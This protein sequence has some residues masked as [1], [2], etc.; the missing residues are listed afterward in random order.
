MAPIK[1]LVKSDLL[2]HRLKVNLKTF[3]SAILKDPDF[4]YVFCL[5][6]ERN[7]L[8]N[9]LLIRLWGG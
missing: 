4:R 5:R 6:M 2:K 8:N 3:C 9:R 7:S 1:E